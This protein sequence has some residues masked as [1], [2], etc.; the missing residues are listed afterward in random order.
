MKSLRH[1]FH[2]SGRASGFTFIELLAVIGLLCALCLTLLPALAHTRQGGQAFQ[3]LNNNR[4]L[5]A[6]W[7]MYADDNREL[8]VYSSDDG[9]TVGNPLNQYAWTGTHMDFNPNNPGNWDVNYDMAKRPLWPYC[10][11]NAELYKCPAD[12]SYVTVSGTPRPRVRSM[13]MNLYL[14]GYAGTTGGWPSVPNYRIYTKLTQIPG[15]AGTSP[16]NIFVF[17]E[18]RPESINWGSF[19]TD[20]TGYPADPTQY[21]FSGDYPA[22][23]HHFATS[24]S[25]CDGHAELHR[26]TDPRTT[27]PQLGGPAVTPPAL[28]SPRNPD[29]AWL[30]DHSTRPK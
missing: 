28:A 26:W 4:Q 25:F 23:Y 6:A 12:I 1:P 17:L 5:C 13:S 24:F 18:M 2:N 8:L 22:I 7:R 10:G 3:C 15:I 20:M 29:I 21:T 30:Q 11:Q 27:P 9:T 14:G 19:F 16:G